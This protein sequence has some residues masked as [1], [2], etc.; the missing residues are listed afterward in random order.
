MVIHLG[1][2]VAMV[3]VANRGNG[4]DDASHYRFLA[5]FLISVLLLCFASLALMCSNCTTSRF[6]HSVSLS[7]LV[8]MQ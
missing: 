8:A 3:G 2:T 5:D 4:E 7:S 6:S 1:R